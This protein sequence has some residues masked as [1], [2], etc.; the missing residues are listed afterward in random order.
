MN[1]SLENHLP[2]LGSETF[3]W[4][5]VLYLRDGGHAPSELMKLAKLHNL[6]CLHVEASNGLTHS[7]T[8]RVIRGWSHEAEFNKAFPRLQSIFLRNQPEITQAALQYLNAFPSFKVFCIS[9]SASKE[10][11]FKGAYGW[12]E[13]Q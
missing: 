11:A 8:D 9:R 1:S 2:A 4:L 3:A 5:T 7:V 13:T 12:H 10:E 6:V